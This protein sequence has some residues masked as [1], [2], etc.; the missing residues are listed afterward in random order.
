ML[1][2]LTFLNK[3]WCEIKQNRRLLLMLSISLLLP[4]FINLIA[5]N[6]LFPM[7]ILVP[8]YVVF[9]VCIVSEFIKA[10]LIE[11]ITMSTLDNI[12]IAPFKKDFFIVYK[13]IIP[14][15]ISFVVT[16]LGMIINDVASMIV[17]EFSDF[18]KMTS[19]TNIL[20]ALIACTTCA[21]GSFYILMRTRKTSANFFTMI[22]GTIMG[23][24]GF[25]AIISNLYHSAIIVVFALIILP[26][27]FVA[28]KVM[29]TSPQPLK[30]SI[31][32][33]WICLFRGQNL[34]FVTAI[35][36][37]D[38]VSIRLLHILEILLYSIL[39][40]VTS[41]MLIFYTLLFLITTY[42]TRKLLY[43]N[44]VEEK[45]NKTFEILSIQKSNMFIFSV[46]SIIPILF[47]LVAS[48]IAIIGSIHHIENIIIVV[49]V[50]LISPIFTFFITKTVNRPKEISYGNIFLF[51]GL[52]LLF[53]GVYGLTILI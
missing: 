42:G 21:W 6:P 19:F 11:E 37:K 2:F 33:Q 52:L 24:I 9:S 40:L 12:L 28:C 26:I 32:R 17:S 39:I 36:V 10:S 38:L 3:E 18:I 8:L 14:I 29:L 22:L 5:Y 41:D 45:L 51:V 15:L 4:F 13:T 50:I 1:A 48:L 43:K 27:L 31:T 35:I 53:I 44:V 23:V 20:I 34:N 46:H 30:K 7:A 25:L 49:L 47:S 16:L